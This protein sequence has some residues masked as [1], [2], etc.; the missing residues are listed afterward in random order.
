MRHL[1]ISLLAADEAVQQMRKKKNQS[2]T[3][4]QTTTTTSSSSSSTSGCTGSPVTDVPPEPAPTDDSGESGDDGDS[5]DFTAMSDFANSSLV[6]NSAQVRGFNVCGN[7][8]TAPAYDSWHGPTSTTPNTYTPWFSYRYTWLPC[9]TWTWSMVKT[10]GVIDNR[11]Y[12]TEHV[13]EL[14]LTNIFLNWLG[15]QDE[16]L[17]HI[18]SQPVPPPP[19]AGDPPLTDAQRWCGF[20]ITPFLTNN[21]AWAPANVYPGAATPALRLQS[22]MTGGSP[23]V[24]RSEF[25]Y[26]E[27]EMNQ[28][29]ENLFSGKNVGVQTS[30]QNALGKLADMMNVVKYLRDS[31]ARINFKI[32]SNRV[33][34]FY[35]DLDTICAQ[36]ATAGQGPCAVGFNSWAD[37]YDLWQLTYLN[38][39]Q[40]QW[41]ANRDTLVA[42]ARAL[43]PAP[44]PNQLTVAAQKI[45]NDRLDAAIL[46]GDVLSDEALS[47]SDGFEI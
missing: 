24:D 45:F 8:L 3:T 44:G 20:T 26:V 38:A 7:T 30:A 37:K 22:L 39:R 32:V 28:R 11:A 27:K 16:A 4:T 18:Q 2:T 15:T 46:P 35:Q 5:S 36:P 13:Y 12:A 10:P 14:Q 29:K 1:L 40:A 21:P 17:A 34:Q 23:P 25:M 9:G 31:T 33:H 19:N 41:F 42:R 6:S 47:W 43:L